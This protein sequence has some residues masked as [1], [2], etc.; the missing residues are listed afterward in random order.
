MGRHPEW[1]RVRAP[2]PA[3]AEGIRAM[4]DLLGRH[5]LTTVCQG[6]IC[7]NAVEC[8]GARTATFM[9]LGD[10]C[11]R[12]CGFCGVPTGDPGGA[13]DRDEPDRLA[14]AVAELGLRYVVLTSVDR[15]DL[16]DGGSALF[17]EAVDRLKERIPG[18]RV[19]VLVPDFRGDRRALGRLLATDA[20]VFGHNVETV[21]R[22]TPRLRD[23]RA[24]YE[25]SLGV[26]ADLSE[27]A[28]GRTVKSGLMVGL[29]E[30]R[31]EI[32]ET[33]VDLRG[34][35]VDVVTVGQYLRPSRRA[36]PVE[37]YVAPAEFAEIEKKA[38]AVGFAAAVSGPLVRSSYHALQ[39]YTESCAY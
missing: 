26:L 3:E 2:S 5:R 24:G 12:A 23:R 29:G 33:L 6:A 22:L 38:R 30:T 21:R 15:D 37:R 27:R 11:T 31:A 35:G 14:A 7:P 19:E 20:D 34:A 16:P 1:I 25:Q 9:L 39:V 8:W 36:V 13:V 10:V 18:I 32:R 4:R 17:A 28:A